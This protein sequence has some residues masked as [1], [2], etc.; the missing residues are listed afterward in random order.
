MALSSASIGTTNEGS[1]PNNTILIA[2]PQIP[3]VGGDLALQNEYSCIIPD[4]GSYGPIQR[5]FT[6]SKH[7]IGLTASLAANCFSRNGAMNASLSM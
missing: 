1:M 4:G 5:R 3:A 2:P 7:D 6:V